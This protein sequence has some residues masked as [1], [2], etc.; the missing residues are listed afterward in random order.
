MIKTHQYYLSPTVR[1]TVEVLLEEDF[2][3]G[4]VVTPAT[5]VETAGQKVEDHSFSDAGFNSKWE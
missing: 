5:T 1:K 4:S 2:L 3:I